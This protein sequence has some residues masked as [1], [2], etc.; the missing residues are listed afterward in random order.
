MVCAGCFCCPLSTVWDMNVRIFWVSAMECMC[1]Q[2][3]PW[4][5][6][7]SERVLGNG[8]KPMLAPR[9]KFPLPDCFE[10]GRTSDAASH[11][12]ANPT[13][14]PL[15]CSGPCSESVPVMHN[16]G[17][18]NN[19]ET[20]TSLFTSVLESRESATCALVL[21]L[22]HLLPSLPRSVDFPSC[23]RHKDVIT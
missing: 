22:N 7:S 21:S 23:S 12:I 9:E 1:V 20:T 19:Q 10:Q 6:L 13:H 16:A 8:V 11:R 4:F 2:T 17:T 18:S 3:R 15:S 5:I 14:Y